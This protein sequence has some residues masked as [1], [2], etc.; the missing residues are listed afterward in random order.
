MD[1]RE[2]TIALVAL[3]ATPVASLAQPVAKGHRIGF[4]GLSSAAE[5]APNL[6]AFVQGLRDLGHHEGKSL[7]I[8]YRWADG[9]EERL[10]ALARELVRLEPD[11]L[12]THGTGVHAAQEATST[13]PIVMGVSSDPVGLGL[14][15]S[16]AKP[17]GN[18][19]GVASQIVE[20]ASKRLQLLK[21]IIPG[22][23]DV[24][25]LSHEANPG[26]R[27]GFVET[28]A[29]AK[30]LGVR[31]HPYWVVAEAEAIHKMFAILVRGRPHGL[32]LQPDSLT[33]RHSVLIARL[34]AE[35]RLPAMGGAKEFV[36]AGG[37]ISY[38]SNFVA[39][40]RLAARYVDR[41]LKGAK[42]ADLPVEQPTAFELAVNLNTAKTLGLALSHALLLRADEVVR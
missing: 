26:A 18:T 41:I 3:A 11:V 8:D 17:G 30:Q 14:I 25:V 20:L 6:Q 10:V 23:K 29:A 9:H 34:A 28:E 31:A 39:G 5:Y 7:F 40:W 37:L 42:P 38:G 36:L 15:K 1:R 12:V 19:T 16:L 21:E 22:L 13:I 35:S 4:L 24:A 27:K 2:S 33:A 32:I